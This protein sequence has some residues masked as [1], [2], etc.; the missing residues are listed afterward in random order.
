MQPCRADL[1]FWLPLLSGGMLRSW[2]IQETTHLSLHRASTSI[3]ETNTVTSPLGRCS[4]GSALRIGTVQTH[5]RSG[6]LQSWEF[7]A[8]FSIVFGFESATFFPQP[9]ETCPHT[10]IFLDFGFPA[11]G[12]NERFALTF[13]G[14]TTSFRKQ[15]LIFGSAISRKRIK[16]RKPALAHDVRKPAPPKDKAD[17]TNGSEGV[18]G[19]QKPEN[20]PTR[21]HVAEQQQTLQDIAGHYRTLQQDTAGH[22]RTLQDTT[23]GTL[24]DTT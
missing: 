18:I 13:W 19:A 23:G 10:F 16:K 7:V 9:A 4:F 5:A 11:L 1:D 2:K 21:A 22:Y 14:L 8:S 15:I 6:Q 3:A 12:P 24:H 20:T 17:A